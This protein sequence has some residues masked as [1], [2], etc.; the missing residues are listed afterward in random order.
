MNV[1][2]RQ[3]LSH[4]AQTVNRECGTGTVIG[5]GSG[6]LLGGS[7]LLL[8]IELAQAETFLANPKTPIKSITL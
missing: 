1:A 4:A 3:K 6:D 8:T 7:F 2:E 5:V